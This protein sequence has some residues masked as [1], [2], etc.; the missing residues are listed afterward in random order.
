MNSRIRSEEDAKSRGRNTAI[1]AGQVGI[2]CKHCASTPANYR[3]KGSSYF[4][5]TMKGL[6]QAAQKMAVNH[7]PSNCRLI[8]E[9]VKDSI[10]VLKKNR[11]R[12]TGG[13]RYWAEGARILGVREVKNGGGLR[14]EK[15][16][17]HPHE[18]PEQNQSAQI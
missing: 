5:S 12:A 8:P 10:K 13:K 7:F 1:Y 16:Q 14:F 17:H 15:Q 4:A 18:V 2:R 9:S 11:R 6:Y 3:F